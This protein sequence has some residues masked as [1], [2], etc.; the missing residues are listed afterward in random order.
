MTPTYSYMKTILEMYQKNIMDAA[1]DTLE[2]SQA[3]LL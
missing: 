2:L 3:V 1:L